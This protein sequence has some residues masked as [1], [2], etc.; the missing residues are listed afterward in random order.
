MKKT[1]RPAEGI[2]RELIQARG[3]DYLRE[4][5][6][7]VNAVQELGASEQDV[8]LL[9][10]LVEVGGHTVLLDAGE[11]SPAVQRASY[12]QV[13]SSLREKK[14]ISEELACRAC[15]SFWRA[16]FNEEPPVTREIP[17]NDHRDPIPVPPDPT[18]P[19]PKTF[20]WIKKAALV[21]VC[22]CI[23]AVVVIALSGTGNSSG[24][25]ETAY[26]DWSTIDLGET[27][28]QLIAAGTGDVYTYMDGS[29]LEMYFDDKDLERCRIYKNKDGNV[30]FLFTAE[31]SAEGDLLKHLTYD[32]AGAIIRTDRYYYDSDHNWIEHDIILGNDVL[33]EITTRTFSPEGNILRSE[34]KAGDDT[35]MYLTKW[36][37]DEEGNTYSITN[38]MD[39]T[40]VEYWGIYDADGNRVRSLEYRLDK[41]GNVTGK[42]EIRFDKNGIQTG[43]YYYDADDQLTGWTEWFFDDARNMIKSADYLPDGTSNGYSICSYDQQGREILQQQYDENGV[44]SREYTPIYGPHDIEIGQAVLK[45]GENLVSTKS[46]NVKSIMG[47]AVIGLF[48]SRGVDD[49][50]DSIT[51]YD[52]M[53]RRFRN[54]DYDEEGRL[55]SEFTALWD[56]YGNDIGHTHLYRAYDGEG[57]LTYDSYTEYDAD[58][59]ETAGNT[60]STW[61]SSDGEYTVTHTDYDGNLISKKKYDASGKLISEE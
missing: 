25:E 39:G 50:S 2:L 33:A 10:Y 21:F 23:L 61:Y 36:E 1:H 17:R 28:H 53:G 59:N 49:Y 46:E 13:I 7:F 16:V 35:V 5:K 30:E 15:G 60:I 31:Y 44:L 8:T 40:S 3:L 47:T 12:T 57:R 38:Y 43:N 55:Y 18:P 14:L 48:Q 29:A 45:Y 37:Y 27:V 42:T 11:K 32:A 20:S 6:C 54:Q 34:T 58:G 26:V 41:E 4:G 19:A 22:L 24:E 9:K 56:S 51:I 52:A